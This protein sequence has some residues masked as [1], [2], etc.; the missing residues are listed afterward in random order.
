M[1]LIKHNEFDTKKIQYTKPEKTGAYYYSTMSYGASTPIHIQ[2]PKMKCRY[3]GTDVLD[4]GTGMIEME[5]LGSDYNLYEKFVHLD[6]RNIKETYNKNKTWFG[7]EIP[8]ELIDDM[9][10]RCSKPIKQGEKPQFSIKIPIVKG[11]VQCPVY[12][13]KRACIDFRKITP[14]C[15]LIAVIHIRGL[16]FLKHHYYCDMYVSQIKVIVPR[17]QKYEIPDTYMIE[18]DEEDE[19]EVLDESVL[20]ELKYRQ[21]REQRLKELQNELEEKQKE[22]E[23]LGV[24]ITQ[25]K[26]TIQSIQMDI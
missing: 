1:S 4:K 22:Y 13:Q 19:T 26:Q 8:L 12:D 9:Y 3:S 2:T 24:D 11:K 21:E 15:E 17:K 5:P 23:R 25:I 7:K 18:D 16:K 6:D 20:A 10:K 14:E